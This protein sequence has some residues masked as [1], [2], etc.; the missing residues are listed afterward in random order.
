[1]RHNGGLFPTSRLPKSACGTNLGPLSLQELKSKLAHL[2]SEE[3]AADVDWL[4]VRELSLELAQDLRTNAPEDYPA[5]LVEEYLSGFDRRAQD[6][7][8]AHGQR[9]QLAAFLRS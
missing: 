3:E 1:M 4:R 5:E 9:S 8:F 2:L 6:P 7:V